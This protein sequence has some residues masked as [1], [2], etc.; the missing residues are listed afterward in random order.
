M[1]TNRLIRHMVMVASLT[2]I[3]GV[4]IGPAQAAD[5]HLKAAVADA[6]E[7]GLGITASGAVK[8]NLKTCMGRIPKDASAGQRMMAEQGCGRDQET[9]KSLDAVPGR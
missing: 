6:Q 1:D 9:R 7:S 3:A 4:A 5:K 8:D 2:L